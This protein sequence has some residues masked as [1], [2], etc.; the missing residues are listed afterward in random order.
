VA[1]LDWLTAAALLGADPNR[2]TWAERV[3]EWKRSGLTAAVFSESEGLN[4]GTLRW[5][6]SRLLQ[7][8]TMSARPPVV[9]VFIDASPS[10]ALEVVLASGARVAVPTRFDEATLRRLLAVL[11]G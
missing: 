10:S 8:S 6:S 7:V 9:E 1:V 2:A 4:A 3:R 11:R 5:W